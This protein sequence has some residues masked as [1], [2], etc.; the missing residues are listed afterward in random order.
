M[1]GQYN[2][3]GAHHQSRTSVGAIVEQFRLGGVKENSFVDLK[4]CNHSGNQQY[5]RFQRD[6]FPVELAKRLLAIL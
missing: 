4:Q 1:A 5:D 6:Q 2:D 3:P